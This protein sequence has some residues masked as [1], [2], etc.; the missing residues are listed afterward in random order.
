[1]S[2]TQPTLAEIVEA[3]LLAA[4]RPLTAEQLQQLFDPL[5]QPSLA[6]LHEALAQVGAAAEGR[7]HE[8]KEV[9]SGWRMQI[10]ARFAP[11]VS[12]LTQE[13]P[14]RYSRALLETLALI[15]YRQPITRA[16]IEA[17]RGVTVSSSI[18]KTLLEQGWIAVI[19]HRELPGRP[20]IYATTRELLDH[21]NLRSL[22][23]LPPLVEFVDLNLNHPQLEFG[24]FELPTREQS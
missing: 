6:Q 14:P 24:E 2:M 4:D 7:G 11:W 19:G 13:K 23:E 5:E 8:L 16:E 20:A 12:R 18:M 1:M 21:F 22:D 17:V 3:V 9:A 10:R 15:L